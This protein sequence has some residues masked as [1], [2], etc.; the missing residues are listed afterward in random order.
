MKLDEVIADLMRASGD[1]LLRVACQLCHNGYL[2]RMPHE[3]VCGTFDTAEQR[4]VAR[5]T[6]RD[7]H[8]A[9]LIGT[10]SC[11]AADGGAAVTG[12]LAARVFSLLY[13]APMYLR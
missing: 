10:P 7:Q 11:I 13:F 8:E 3:A 9:V 1:R 12:K 4:I 2:A 6:N 5:P